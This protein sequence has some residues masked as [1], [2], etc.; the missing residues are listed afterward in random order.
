[1]D[2]R[3]LGCRISVLLAAAIVA[4]TPCPVANAAAGAAAPVRTLN[5]SG[6]VTSSGSASHVVAWWKVPSISCAPLENSNA[7][8][9][10]GLGGGENEPPLVQV[11]V[12]S[13]CAAGVPLHHAFT[14]IV[15]S[16]AAGVPI[17][18]I[19]NTGDR[20]EAEVRH[21]GGSE[22]SVRFTNN[23]CWCGDFTA[24]VTQPDLSVT[25]K[26]AEWIVEAG[27]AAMNGGAFGQGQSNF[28][29]H[30]FESAFFNDR[31]LAEGDTVKH[32]AVNSSGS[33]KV[34]VTDIS[35]FGGHGPNFD[36]S[37]LGP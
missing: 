7:S 31:L 27:E 26:T 14:Q 1:M 17:V 10:V 29:T 5:W 24:E 28:G 20:V 3:R 13:G 21:L 30:R 37:W 9:W 16:Q 18:M 32:V 36:V 2:L 25:P 34:A 22:Y 23:A 8:Q 12:V 33:P 4:L 35:Q 19:V 6:H 15:P 11:G